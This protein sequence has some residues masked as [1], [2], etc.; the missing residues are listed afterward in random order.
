MDSRGP[1]TVRQAVA[2]A[3]LVLAEA[4][5]PTPDVDARLLAEHV[6]GRSLY[7]VPSAATF[8]EASGDRAQTLFAELVGRRRHRE[9]LQHITGLMAF[10]HLTLSAAPGAFVVRPE[11][12][13]VAGEAVDAAAAV[14]STGRAPVV[15]DLCT[16]SGAIALAV[17][18]EVPGA[19]V[20]AVELSPAALRVARRNVDALAPA[21]QLVA[22]DAATALPELDGTVDVVVSNPPY[23]PP[24]AV[25]RETEV[26]EHDPDLALYGGGIDGL[27]VPRAVV[28]TA[29]RL[30]VDG[31]V[32]VMEHAEVQ[33][34]TVRQIAAAAGL[35][36]VRTGRD[37]T[38]RDRYVVARR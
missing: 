20:H 30:L 10:R 35:R 31:G 34:A 38:G 17:A 18:T 16:G 1:V 8:A 2:G 26:R 4:G 37:L 22:G 28:R 32:F 25:P 24:D 36:D 29:A 14:A 13:V 19:V 3:A 33:A 21:V 11:T 9:P 23:I 7:L 15:V 12:E 6:L 27:D 5:V